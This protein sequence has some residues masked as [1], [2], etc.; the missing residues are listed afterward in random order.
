M[1]KDG[2]VAVCIS[3]YSSQTLATQQRK[4]E[5]GKKKKTEFITFLHAVQLVK[6]YKKVGT[7]VARSMKQNLPNCYSKL[8]QSLFFFWFSTPSKSQN[9]FNLQTKKQG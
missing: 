9:D 8:S 4:V 2:Y 1:R 7:S 5:K 6:I 3:T